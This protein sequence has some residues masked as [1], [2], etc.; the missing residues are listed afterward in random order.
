M[1]PQ[2]RNRIV[3]MFFPII[4]VRKRLIAR[5]SHKHTIFITARI[6]VLMHIHNSNCSN[7][8]HIMNTVNTLVA[9]V[10]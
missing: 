10:L 1:G 2:V 7:G 6:A 4:G 5:S 3:R 8:Y 9:I